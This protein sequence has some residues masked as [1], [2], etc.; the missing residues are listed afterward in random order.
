MGSKFEGR[1]LTY[2]VEPRGGA[3]RERLADVAESVHL[4]GDLLL[5][6][7]RI[8]QR[9]LS[10]LVRDAGGLDDG[11][12]LALL[13]DHE[14]RLEGDLRW[15]HA[16]VHTRWAHAGCTGGGRGTR[17]VQVHAGHAAGVH[18]TCTRMRMRMRTR[19]RGA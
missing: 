19:I 7:L 6:H 14:Q 17:E 16:V 5:G 13:R 2:V 11:L 8:A 9:L 12:V 15:A 3:Q 4:R 18:C 1:S 10:A